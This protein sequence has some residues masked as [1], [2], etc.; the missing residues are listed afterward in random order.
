MGHGFAP[1][2]A[3]LREDMMS[4]FHL[5]TLPGY[6]WPVLPDAAISQV[7]VAF[8]ELQ[9]TQWLA[10]HE[11]EQCQLEQLRALL[12]HCITSVPYYRKTLPQ[13]GITPA[14]IR[15]LADFRRVPLLPRRA[16]QENFPDFAAAQ[17]PPG[18]VP[19]ST[20]RTS[21]SS[22]TPT[23]VYR[24]NMVDLW[25]HA[26]YLRDLEWCGV[27]PTCTLAAI[28]LMEAS[29]GTLEALLQGASLPCWSPALDPLLQTGPSF[30]MDIRQDP[31]VQLQWLRRMAPDYLLSYPSNLEALANLARPDG[32]LPGLR[33]ILAIGSVLTPEARTVIEAA[34][35][36]AVKNTYSCAEAGYLASPCPAGAGWHVHAENVLL[37]V[38]TEDGQPCAPGESGRVFITTLHNLRAPL[39]RYELGDVATIGPHP[40]ACGRGLPLL[41]WVEGSRSPMFRL[42]DGRR[43]HSSSLSQRLREVGGHWQHQVVQQDIGHIVVRLA[44]N[45]DWSSDHGAA[46]QRVIQEFFEG[47]L[48]VAVESRDRLPLPPSGKFQSMICELE[49][50]GAAP[51]QTAI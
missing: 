27:D 47:P 30:G 51:P 14:T 25:W 44:V 11:L 29:G 35:G 41:T 3:F 1:I 32:P 12:A 7:W 39:V 36:V 48:H 9:R 16:Y 18:T 45:A 33:G 5:R 8:L 50:H 42:A 19:T 6:A 46:V 24:T 10:R 21:G 23:A 15:T 31:R 38:L 37:E 22:G 17:L 34:F 4:V 28:R 2:G 49:K 20:G 40:C 26:C 13:A 43:K